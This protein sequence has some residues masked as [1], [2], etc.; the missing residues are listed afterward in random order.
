MRGCAYSVRRGRSKHE[1]HGRQPDDD[2]KRLWEMCVC[3]KSMAIRSAVI[4]SP[5]GSF[6]A[7]RLSSTMA[8]LFYAFIMYGPQIAHPPVPTNPLHILSVFFLRGG[9]TSVQI[10]TI[11]DQV[12][13]DRLHIRI[14]DCVERRRTCRDIDGLNQTGKKRQ[15]LSVDAF[16]HMLIIDLFMF[17]S[18]FLFFGMA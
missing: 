7:P 9:G 13:M 12:E 10:C 14:L 1:V 3:V 18:F 2:W 11:Y 17:I 4:P 5:S 6:V 8:R 15:T 16:Y